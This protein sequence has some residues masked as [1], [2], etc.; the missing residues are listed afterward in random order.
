[1]AISFFDGYC[2]SYEAIA[3]G[4]VIATTTEDST[5]SSTRT[6]SQVSAP[7]TATVTETT[8][9]TTSISPT[10]RATVPTLPQ[11]IQS[12]SF[13]GAQP[14]HRA[15]PLVQPFGLVMGMLAYREERR[16]F[17]CGPKLRGADH[18]REGEAKILGTAFTYPKSLGE[19]L[20][21]WNS[22]PTNEVNASLDPLFASD[23][24]YFMESLAATTLP[25]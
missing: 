5:M 22:G 6:T 23:P 11:G 17:T 20:A 21:P 16:T 4:S 18:Q 19:L 10:S 24:I 1:M 13:S 7:R 8:E 12:T 2:S 15:E 3:A 25:K 9:Y 14:K